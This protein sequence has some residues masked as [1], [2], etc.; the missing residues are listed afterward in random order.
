MNMPKPTIS[1]KAASENRGNQKRHAR[2]APNTPRTSALAISDTAVAKTKY[3]VNA[4]IAIMT[5]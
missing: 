3:S 4:I 5:M 1:N 2:Q